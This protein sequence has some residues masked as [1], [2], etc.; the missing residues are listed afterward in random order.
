M[1]F[2]NIGGGAVSGHEVRLMSMWWKMGNLACPQ[3]EK[4]TQGPLLPHKYCMGYGG[5]PTQITWE[6]GNIRKFYFL[7]VG[8]GKLFK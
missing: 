8:E 6:M 7:V 4:G 1:A 5:I 2:N 3:I